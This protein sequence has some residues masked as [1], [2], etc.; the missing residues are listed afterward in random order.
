[1]DQ[2]ESLSHVEVEDVDRSVRMAAR[3]GTWRASSY[4][5]WGRAKG[6]RGSEQFTFGELKQAWKSGVV[7]RHSVWKR[8][9]VTCIGALMM[10]AGLLSSFVVIGPPWMKVLMGSLLLYVLSRMS[11]GLWRACR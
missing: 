11:W 8:R 7:W 1:M 2:D 3:P 4:R 5:A 6:R 10:T 9:F